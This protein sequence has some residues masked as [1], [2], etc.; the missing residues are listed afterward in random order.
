MTPEKISD[1]RESGSKKTEKKQ[2]SVRSR[3]PAPREVS[4]EHEIDLDTIEKLRSDS[5]LWHKVQ[6]QLK[7]HGLL[8][9]L[10]SSSSARTLAPVV[11]LRTVK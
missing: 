5:K 8:S 10:S 7:E 1:D 11:T 4:Y 9:D 6:K 3:L 2:S